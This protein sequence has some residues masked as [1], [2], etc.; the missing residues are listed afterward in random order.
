MC[1]CT[2][3]IYQ[4]YQMKLLSLT[5]LTKLKVMA[6]PM[7]LLRHSRKLDRD[8]AGVMPFK[9]EGI[10]SSIGQSSSLLSVWFKC[11]AFPSPLLS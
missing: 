9:D 5:L 1:K 10:A 11:G 3:Y 8:I 6:T 2:V 4:M 7:I